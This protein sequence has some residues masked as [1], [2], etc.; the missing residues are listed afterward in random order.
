MGVVHGKSVGKG[1]EDKGLNL[2]QL[3]ARVDRISID[4]LGR[5]KDDFIIKAVNELF[6][7]NNFEEMLHQSRAVKT[8]LESLGCFQNIVIHVDTSS[9]PKATPDCGYEVTFIVRE[10]K[11]IAGGVHTMVGTNNEGL[12]V[13]SAKAPNIL[14]RG[15]RLHGEFS[16]GNKQTKSFNVTLTKPL[17]TKFNASVAGTVFNQDQDWTMSKY[18][19]RESGIVLDFSF[20]SFNNLKHCL[21]WE[22]TIRDLGVG[23][24]YA[25]FAIRENAGNTLKSSLRHILTYDTRRTLLFPSSGI[26]SKFTTELAGVGGNVGFFKNDM[27]LQ[28]DVPLLTDFVLQ[29]T[30]GGGYM[31]PVDP[32]KKSIIV[33]DHFFLG[34]P[35]TFRG[36]D[37]RGAGPSSDGTFLGAKMYWCAGLSLFTPLPF[38]PSV[39]GFGEYFR[40]HFFANIGNIGNLSVADGLP[41]LLHQARL[42]YGIGL[43][44][45]LGHFARVEVNYC[46]PMWTQDG[47]RAVH[48]VQI[49]LGTSL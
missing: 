29:G 43:A 28:V 49:G 42:A 9:G 17:L 3:H 16:Y 24:R 25:A 15:E 22:G 11:Q 2:K 41:S 20:F 23:N 14:G 44:L 31:V 33:C 38:R 39:G 26:L 48:G 1:E 8:K 21:Q 10:L 47:D 45:R 13:A 37:M 27:L 12:L 4:G 18:K 5:T 6:K 35:V 7:V 40:T 46:F 30:F 36:F 19:L 34:G 32:A